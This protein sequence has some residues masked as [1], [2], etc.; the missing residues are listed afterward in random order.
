[1]AS[2]RN[3][4]KVLGVVCVRA[5]VCICV[6]SSVCMCLCIQEA[7]QKRKDIMSQKQKL[8]EKLVEEQK[9]HRSGTMHP[10]SRGCSV[11]SAASLACRNTRELG[12]VSVAK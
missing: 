8:L 12:N 3:L 9:V 5:C 2:Y 1:M 4:S 11:L 10:L 7:L 6:R